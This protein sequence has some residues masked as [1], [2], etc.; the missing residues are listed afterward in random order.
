MSKCGHYSALFRKEIDMVQVKR[1]NGCWRFRTSVGRWIEVN[2][3][4]LIDV[5]VDPDIEIIHEICPDCQAVED[6][7][8]GV[9]QTKSG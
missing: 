3:K 7:R 4:E 2:E 9:L 1:C 6:K 5:I 8:K